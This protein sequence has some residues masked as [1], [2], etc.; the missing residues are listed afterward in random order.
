MK[1]TFLGTGTSQGVPMI[2]CECPVCTSLDYRDKRLRTSVLIEVNSVRFI[3]DTGPDFRQQMLR[4]RVKRLDA[5]VFTHQHKDH[6]AGL[7]E[8]R[9]FNYAQKENMPVYATERVCKQLKIE[10]AYAFEA[11]K[12]PGVPLIDL[13]QFGDEPFEIK[14]VKI[15]PVTVMHHMLPVTGFRIGNFTYITDANRIDPA[16]RDKIRGSEIM[17]LN[18]L[19]REPHPSHFTLQE[20]LDVIADIN[21]RAAYL[22][23]ISHRLGR[24]AEVQP[25][26]PPNVFL[27]WDGLTLECGEC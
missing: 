20:S 4:E 22:T 10:F 24:H 8:V 14:G 3:I 1:V 11:F 13:Y 9:S 18:G 21:P 7:D 5:V 27:A 16:E 23:H 19:Q 15:T 6:I 17:V 2:A 25:T 12:Y 26:L